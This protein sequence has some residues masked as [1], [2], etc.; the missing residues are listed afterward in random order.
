MFQ[1]QGILF[2]TYPCIMSVNIINIFSGLLKFSQLM[3]DFNTEGIIMF[4]VTLS[5]VFLTSLWQVEGNVKYIYYSWYS[6]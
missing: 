3:L 6:L 5:L 4:A 2:T 1:N